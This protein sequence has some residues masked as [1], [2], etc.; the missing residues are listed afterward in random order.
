[1]S[2]TPTNKPSTARSKVT[3]K[4]T[5]GAPPIFIPIGAL[6]GIVLLV[7]AVII[8]T[9]DDEEVNTGPTPTTIP[10]PV[11][12]SGAEVIEGMLLYTAESV[13]FSV[14]AAPDQENEEQSTEACGQVEVILAEANATVFYLDTST[15]DEQYWIYARR[16]DDTGWNGWLPLS[17]LS[18]ALPEGCTAE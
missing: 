11:L 17:T 4:K 2:N 8:A 15:E 5:G 10:A 1:M 7:L 16:T 9:S 6:I 13:P 3:P 18:E 12:E 14:I